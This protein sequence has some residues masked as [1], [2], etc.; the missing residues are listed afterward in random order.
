M[1]FINKRNL[2]GN[3]YNA[4][5]LCEYQREIKLIRYQEKNEN[6]SYN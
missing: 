2:F 5:A 3:E 4:Y 6:S 1:S